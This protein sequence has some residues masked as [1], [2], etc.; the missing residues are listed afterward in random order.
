MV[1][2]V[3]Q[4]FTRPER[5][6]WASRTSHLAG[7]NWWNTCKGVQK[8]LDVLK[9]QRLAFEAIDLVK[10]NQKR[11]KPFKPILNEQHYFNS[12]VPNKLES[13]QMI[14]KPV[15]NAFRMSTSCLRMQQT[16]ALCFKV[17]LAGP[18]SFVLRKVTSNKLPQSTF[19]GCM[20][21]RYIHN[22]HGAHHIIVGYYWGSIIDPICFTTFGSWDHPHTTFVIWLIKHAYFP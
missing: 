6:N 5:A 13:I 1:L 21:T 17:A 18:F 22:I 7:S 9:I 19:V 12:A 8:P 20:C 11:S 10:N 15:H 4:P 2:A 3:H 16:V 14:S